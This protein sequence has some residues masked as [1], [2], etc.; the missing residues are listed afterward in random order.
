TSSVCPYLSC[1]EDDLC[2]L[3]MLAYNYLRSHKDRE[4]EEVLKRITVLDSLDEAALINLETVQKAQSQYA[5]ALFN[6]RRAFALDPVRE[7]ANNNVNLEFGG[8]YVL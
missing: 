1:H 8:T 3:N 2:L 6:Y 4:A 7:V 5:D